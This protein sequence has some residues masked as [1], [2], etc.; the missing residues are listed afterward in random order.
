M[1]LKKDFMTMKLQIFCGSAATNEKKTNIISIKKYY[2]NDNK[3]LLSGRAAK[4]L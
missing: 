2:S 4:D 1:H 3:N